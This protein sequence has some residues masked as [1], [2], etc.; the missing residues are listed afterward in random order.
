MFWISAGNS[1]DNSE[2]FSLLLSSA[3]TVKAFSAWVGGSTRIWEGTQVGQL[4]PTD[5]RDIL[6]H[7]ASCSTYKAGGRRRKG[8]MFGVMVFVSPTNCYA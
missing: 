3:Y 6:D 1:V 7:M 2:M 5:Q 4:T 8:G